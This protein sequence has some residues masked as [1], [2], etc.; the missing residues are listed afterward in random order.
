MD[1]ANTHLHFQSG[2]L[3]INLGFSHVAVVVPKS[4]EHLD[5]KQLQP[6]D[7]NEI[8]TVVCQLGEPWE[9][10]ALSQRCRHTLQNSFRLCCFGAQ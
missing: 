7:L 4:E 9:L 8:K 1:T 6:L 2:C 10:S 5:K 3:F